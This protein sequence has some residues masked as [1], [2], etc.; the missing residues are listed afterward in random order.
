VFEF[1]QG[2]GRLDAEL[3]GED[4]SQPLVCR[5]GVRLAVRAVQRRDEQLPKALTQGVAINQP[6]ELSDRLRVPAD[7][8]LGGEVVLGR[9]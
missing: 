2:G 9:R 7:G 5:E 6:L 1:S 4:P 8:Q 3:V